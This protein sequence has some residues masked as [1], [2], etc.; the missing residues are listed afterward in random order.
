MRRCAARCKRVA[1]PWSTQRRSLPV[2]Q[3]PRL[4][5][6]T[7]TAVSCDSGTRMVRAVQWPSAP[8]VHLARSTS[9]KCAARCPACTASK[10]NRHVVNW[11]FSDEDHLNNATNARRKFGPK[12]ERHVLGVRSLWQAALSGGRRELVRKT[13]WRLCTHGAWNSRSVLRCSRLTESSPASQSL[14]P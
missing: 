3:M 14:I 8:A 11:S 6:C 9:L 10:R 7:M 2:G 1:R 12:H 4:T 13:R 5:P